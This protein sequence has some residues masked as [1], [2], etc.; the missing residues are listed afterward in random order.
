MSRHAAPCFDTC[1]ISRQADPFRDQGK[2]TTL[3]VL[4]RVIDVAHRGAG[5]RLRKLHVQEMSFLSGYDGRDFL[6]KDSFPPELL[7][8]LES[9]TIT[10]MLQKNVYGQIRCIC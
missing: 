8:S 6:A 2:P 5:I 4:R 1:D 9:A 7:G 3:N 10:I